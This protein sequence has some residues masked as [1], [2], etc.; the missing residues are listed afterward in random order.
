M[1]VQLQRV[2]E[3]DAIGEKQPTPFSHATYTSTKDVENPPLPRVDRI[4]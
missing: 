3:I 4:P 2:E 1:S